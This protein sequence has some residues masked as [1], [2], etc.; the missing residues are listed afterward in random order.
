MSVRLVSE[1]RRWWLSEKCSEPPSHGIVFFGI[2]SCNLSRA[3]RIKVNKSNKRKIN[4]LKLVSKFIN[5][6]V[7][8]LCSW[9]RLL[10]QPQHHVPARPATSRSRTTIGTVGTRDSSSSTLLWGDR[11]R[12]TVQNRALKPDI[13]RYLDRYLNQSR[14]LFK[15]RFRACRLLHQVHD[16]AESRLNLLPGSGKKAYC[17][18]NRTRETRF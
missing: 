12:A 15:K 1:R 9:S 16:N 10:A 5:V 17:I 18:W 8:R 7:R 14:P 3:R 11:N 2:I 13:Y 4:E 6:V